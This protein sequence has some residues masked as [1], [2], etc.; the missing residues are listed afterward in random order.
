MKIYVL[1]RAARCPGD[2]FVSRLLPK[3]FKRKS[4]AVAELS[5][6]KHND[7]RYAELHIK[8]LSVPFG[9]ID[10]VDDVIEI[11]N[12]E[13]VLNKDLRFRDWTYHRWE[14]EFRRAACEDSE[15]SVKELVQACDWWKF[16][17]VTECQID[18]PVFVSACPWF[19]DHPEC[20]QIHLDNSLWS[21]IFEYHPEF[22]SRCQVWD[23][24]SG[25]D[26][27][28]ILAC[29]PEFINRCAW[30]KL[31]GENWVSLIKRRP[32]FAGRCAWDKLTGENWVSLIHAQPEFAGRCAW[33]KL[34]GADWVSLVNIRPEFAG[35]CDWEK[36]TVD[37]WVVYLANL[38]KH[39]GDSDQTEF[40][41]NES[42]AVHHLLRL[43]P[44]SSYM[45]DVSGLDF[46][47]WVG[48]FKRHCELLRYCDWCRWS[49]QQLKVLADSGIDLATVCDWD[50]VRF[51]SSDCTEFLLD[52]P[53]WRM[54]YKGERIIDLT[55]V[56]SLSENAVNRAL[57][58]G[59]QLKDGDTWAFVL[60][61]GRANDTMCKW[62]MLVPYN[63]RD[64]LIAR[65]D[66]IVKLPRGFLT[67]RNWASVLERQ[68]S[69]AKYCEWEKVCVHDKEVL[70]EVRPELFS[71]SNK[72][73]RL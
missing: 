23:E 24:F 71:I 60:I 72:E 34:T 20:S 29:R 62:D 56:K 13:H 50:T 6:I 33:N 39:I 22:A 61:M 68:P 51:S 54:H 15:F 64:V 40:K 35:E 63:W 46:E 19:M 18:M 1:V 2:P 17:G 3:A 48:L 31:T 16:D 11:E 53:A 47:Q 4:Q 5:K 14:W 9:R 55:L 38:L 59:W 41:E 12:W 73:E 70:K 44:N 21:L 49:Y 27:A 43:L 7:E 58:D 42:R 28:D 8:S 37:D 67:G 26:W 66:L 36:L 25:R 57:L 45:V 65:P 30:D 10:F 32:E 69:L 52:A